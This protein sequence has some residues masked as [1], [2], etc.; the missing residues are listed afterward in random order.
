LRALRSLRENIFHTKPAKY[1]KVS[2]EPQLT[3][4]AQKV[5]LFF[6]LRALRSLRE[7]LFSQ[8]FYFIMK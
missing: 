5:I 7:N 2:F 8:R 4:R 6:P 1:A 3:H